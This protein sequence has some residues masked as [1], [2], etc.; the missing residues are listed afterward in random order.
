M[1]NVMQSKA[2]PRLFGVRV[3]PLRL[4]DI[5]D[6]IRVVV[7]NNQRLLVCNLHVRGANLA[8]EQAWFRNFLNS[9]DIVYCDGM[10][11]KLGLQLLGYRLPERLTL[12]D[13][14]WRLAGSMEA[15]GASAYL[16]GNPPGVAEAAAK[17]LTEQFCELKIAGTHDGYFQKET[18]SLENEQVIAQIN[19]ARP[20]VL[21]VGFGMPLQEKWL[22]ENWPRLDVRV[23]IACGAIFEYIAGTLPRG[24]RWMTEHYL[25]WLARLFISPRRYWK[26]YLRDNPLF[27]WR[28]AQ[29]RLHPTIFE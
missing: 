16:L 28:V 20:D 3:D 8:Y 27:I 19:M 13:W 2:E 22:M 5:L 26:R 9:A 6:R 4:D 25:E 10:G 23:A 21:F 1:S 14:M 15:Q 18:G 17:K 11:V 12:A 7:E 29:Q 24:P